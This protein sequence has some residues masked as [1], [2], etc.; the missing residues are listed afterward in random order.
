MEMESASAPSKFRF[1]D[2]SEPESENSSEPSSDVVSAVTPSNTRHHDPDLQIESIT[3]RGIKHLC[4]ELRE[5]QEAANEDLQKNIFSKYSTFLRIL[6]E[7]IGMENELVQLENHFI[8]HK[9]QVKD[10][11]DR[12][13]PK[14]LSI[15]I[16]LEDNIDFVSS[17][18]NELEVHINEC[19]ENLDVLI[20]ENRI[21]EAL[22]L[23]ESA[24]E[25]Y[26]QDCSHGDIALYNSLISEKKS[27]LIQQM[28]Q[29]AENHR[30][31]GP[32]LQRTLAGLNRLG[33]SQLAIKLL[34]K[35]YHLRI[36]TGTDNLQWAKSSSSEIYIRELARFVFSMISQAARSF[37]VLCGE[38]SPYASE[39]ILW[40]NEETKSFIIGFDKYIKGASAISGGLHSAVKA[41]KFAVMYCSLLENQ[42]LV[43]RPYL[44]KHLSP[45]MEEILSTHI[46]HFKKVIGIFSAS[47]PWILEKY[48]VSGVF[49]GAGSSSLTAEEQH[50][51]CLLTASGRKV[52]TLL[53]A[54]V[55]D[56]SPLVSLQMGSL[57]ISGITKLFKEYIVILERALTRE[58]STSEQGSPIIKAETI[59]QQVS[60]LANLSTLM[61]FLSIM[62][63]NIF[64]SSDQIDLQVLENHSIVQQQQELDDFLLFIEEGSNKLRNV[65]CQQLIQRVLSTYQRHQIFS[66]S[67]HNDKFDANTIHHPMPSGIFQVLFLEL[68]KIE[69][70]EEENVFEV[71]WMVGLLRELMESMFIWVSNN[72]DI[73]ATT[74]ENVSSQT[75]QAKQVLIP[76]LLFILLDFIVGG[77]EFILDV[78]FLV[79]IGMY[80]GYFSKD[81]LL[82]LTLMKSTFN[83]AGL[84]PFKDVDD[85]DWA[86][87]AA[88]K[89]IQRL[90]EIEKTS[91]HQK[92]ESHEHDNQINQSA[93]RCD[94]SEEDD[95]NSSYNNVVDTVDSEK[96][97]VTKHDLK[98]AIDAKT[99]SVGELENIDFEEATDTK[100][101]ELSPTSSVGEL[102][103][104]SEETEP[105]TDE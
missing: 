31:A 20:P 33:D 75:D 26:S 36:E 102:E 47:D 28:T 91:L 87:D 18:P 3:G 39:L 97:E 65:F 48:L 104:N 16:A 84:D 96:H 25:Q 46:N 57:V 85:D 70:L 51:Y 37:A 55:E 98:V 38:T 53:Q 13:Y 27:M 19:L 14:I 32:E 66:A 52:L 43:L 105:K 103:Q 100:N 2:H 62:V 44:V 68:R 99:D 79:E 93:H 83:S 41:V 90:L 34:L 5:L 58:T 86:I 95:K 8:S 24:D 72:K 11:I 35:H 63:K 76:S 12:I 64:S 29:I 56:I 78:E 69:Q 21:D 89:T 40:A 81:P 17:P 4:D 67:N 60:I 10:L 50:D 45:C 74:E 9:K 88:T 30:T 71:N 49:V 59:P 77:H 1:R 73:L 92:K 23:L 7:V 82:L 6:E 54:I 101:D 22:Q 42:K 80:G 94:F 15:E 61:Q